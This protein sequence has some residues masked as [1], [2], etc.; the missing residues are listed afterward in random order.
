MLRVMIKV[1]VFELVSEEV[2]VL[3]EVGDVPGL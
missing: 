2:D 3:L 1:Q